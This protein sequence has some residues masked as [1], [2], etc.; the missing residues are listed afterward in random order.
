LSARDAANLQDLH[1]DIGLEPEAVYMVNGGRHP[2]A[3]RIHGTTLVRIVGWWRWLLAA[4]FGV[5][6]VAILERGT[7]AAAPMVLLDWETYSRLMLGA[8]PESL[9]SIG[10]DEA[11]ADMARNEAE[12]AGHETGGA[13]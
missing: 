3:F 9:S 12:H 4:V 5:R 2:R 13:F 8:R 1:R 6:G 10:L 7:G 11:P